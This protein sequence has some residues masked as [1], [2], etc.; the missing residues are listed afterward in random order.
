MASTLTFTSAPFLQGLTASTAN[1]TSNTRYDILSADATYARRIYGI[2]ITSTD[3]GAQ[4]VKIHLHD[5]TTAYQVFTINVPLSS[6]NTT[7]AAAID[8]MGSVYG[9]ALLQKQRDANGVPYFNIPAG[10]KLQMEYN[11]ALLAAE[12]LY[13]LVFGETYA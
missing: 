4:T 6:G 5:G 8:I 2:S 7:T 12:G 3:T 9:A 13:V 10:W 11:T 1:S